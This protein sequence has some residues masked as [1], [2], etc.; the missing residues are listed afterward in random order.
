MWRDLIRR[1][2]E[3][4][5][6]H[7]ASV[8]VKETFQGRTVWDGVVEVF[9]L[10]GHPTAER[11]YAGSH[12]TDDPASPKRHVTAL[13]AEAVTSPILAVRAAIIQEF[14]TMPQPKPK[15]MGR[16]VLPKG[17]AKERIV[18]IRF[19]AAEIKRIESAARAS[20]QTVSG[21]IRSAI[22]TVMEAQ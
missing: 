18:P 12:Y 8:P 11:L 13:Q 1:L 9:D 21:W 17:E 14:E 16:P 5:S 4:D 20:R 7:V 3:A 22:T 15:K 19:K 10:T 6:K 2:H